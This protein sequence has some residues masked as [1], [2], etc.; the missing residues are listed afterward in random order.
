MRKG[1]LI[2]KGAA[3]ALTVAFLALVRPDP[4]PTRVG[5]TVTAV[6]MYE[7]LKYI[8]WYVRREVRRRKARRNVWAMRYDGRRWAEMEFQPI[9]IIS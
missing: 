8:V 5:L 6:L 2:N 7:A 4:E 3:A 1:E 9:K